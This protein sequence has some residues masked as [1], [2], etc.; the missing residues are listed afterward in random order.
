MATSPHVPE[1]RRTPGPPAA[2]DDWRALRRTAD[3]PVDGIL[4]DLDD[5]LARLD[6][7]LAD[8]GAA[9]KAAARAS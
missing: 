4:H 8:V 7:R 6:R 3:M 2:H 1:R 9:L 5:G